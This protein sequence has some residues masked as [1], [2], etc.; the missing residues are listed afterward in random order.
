MGE[1]IFVVFGGDLRKLRT[2]E[3]AGNGKFYWTV[4]GGHHYRKGQTRETLYENH[5]LWPC[6]SEL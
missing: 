6:T 5:F 3:D 1:G 2:V 4:L